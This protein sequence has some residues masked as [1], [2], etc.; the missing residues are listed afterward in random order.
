M[1]FHVP[2]IRKCNWE[3]QGLAQAVR[4]GRGCRGGRA[5]DRDSPCPLCQ[6]RLSSLPGKEALPFP[7]MPLFFSCF[8]FRK[9]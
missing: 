1:S 8:S 2:L 3:S 7:L 9:Q 4:M 5:Q 6:A